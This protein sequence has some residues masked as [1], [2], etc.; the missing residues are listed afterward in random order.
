MFLWHHRKNILNNRLKFDEHLTNVP[1]ISKNIWLLRKLQNILPRPALLTIYKCFIRSHLDYGD[2]TYDQAYTLPFN[3]KLETIQ[4]NTAL[5]LTMAIRGSSREKLY[6]E[7]GF[8]SL[9]LRR[10]RKLC[11]FYNIYNKQAPGYLT[12]L[13]ATCNAVY[14]TRRIANIPSLRF[15][16]IFLKIHFPHQLS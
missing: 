5:A 12:E 15:K 11:C 9:Q 4:Y 14:Q 13:I 1:K 10:W 2:T 6:Q 8:G 16:H 7:L 3:Q